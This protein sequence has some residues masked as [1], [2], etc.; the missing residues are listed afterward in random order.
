MQ[1]IYYWSINW[2]LSQ[3]SNAIN[4]HC[5]HGTM[6]GFLYL[7][8]VSLKC[9]RNVIDLCDL[10]VLCVPPMCAGTSVCGNAS[11]HLCLRVCTQHFPPSSPYPSAHVSC[12]LGEFLGG[13]YA[14]PRTLLVLLLR[15]KLFTS[16]CCYFSM[17]VCLFVWGRVFNYQGHVNL[18]SNPSAS[19]AL[20][21]QALANTPR[22]FSWILSN[23]IFG[24]Q[25]LS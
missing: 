9:Y 12:M 10:C 17:F 13:S 19:P 4:T 18:T 3:K 23:L 11:T 25:A 21:L 14:G 16:I 24:Q 6:W 15:S 7:Y 20:R 2:I 1:E 8:Y 5:F 22:F